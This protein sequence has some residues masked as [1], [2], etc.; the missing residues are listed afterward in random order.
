MSRCSHPAPNRL[1]SQILRYLYSKL[2]LNIGKA[3]YRG[4][5][6]SNRDNFDTRRKYLMNFLRA[7]DLE[8]FLNGAAEHPLIDKKGKTAAGST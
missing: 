2:I 1:D 8:D 6:L 5:V 7:E 4:T 3:I